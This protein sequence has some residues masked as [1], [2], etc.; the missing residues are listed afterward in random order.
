MAT[1][2][3]QETL[4]DE[5]LR[6]LARSW[7]DAWAAHDAS[8][9]ADH[10]TEDAVYEDPAF[11]EAVRG[12]DAFREQAQNMLDSV[13]DIEVKQRTLMRSIDDAQVGATEWTLT[14]TFNGA[15]MAASGFAPTGQRVEMHGMSRVELRGDKVARLVQYYDTTEFGRQVGAVPKRGS[16][17]ERIGLMLQKMAA[18]RMRKRG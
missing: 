11:P 15:A 4:T 13:P 16:V 2:T 18:R 8:R 5:A 9:I 12:R 10:M 17:G 7:D 6:E 1:P 3:T 14:G